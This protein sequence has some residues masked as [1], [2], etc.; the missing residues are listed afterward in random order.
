MI[1]KVVRDHKPQPLTSVKD[2][3]DSPPSPTSWRL[4]AA[5]QGGRFVTLSKTAK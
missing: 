1:T 3:Q 5:R 2:F 4:R